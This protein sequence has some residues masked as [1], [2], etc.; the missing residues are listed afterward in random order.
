MSNEKS[1]KLAETAF[2][3]ALTELSTPEQ[4]VAALETNEKLQDGTLEQLLAAFEDAA[5]SDGDSTQFWDARDLARLLDYSDYRNFLTSVERAKQAC[6]LSGIPLED[7]FVDATEMVE[8]GSA[9]LREVETIRLS[10]YACYLIAQNADARK[11]PVA[12]AQTYFAI[13]ARRQ[14]T[15]DEAESYRP[16]PEDEKRVLLRE[17]IKEHNKNLASAAKQAG[18]V[19]PLDFAIFQ[20]AGYQ[21]LYGGLDKSGIARRKGIKAKQNILDHMGSTELAANLFRA[22]QTEE[23][24]TRDGIRGKEAANRTHHEVGAEVR[25]AIQNIGGTMPEH[26]PV[27][28]DIVKVERRLKKALT[29]KDD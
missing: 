13:Q 26:L 24:L 6:R 11:Q 29:K 25:R 1:K 9:A 18:V 23:K 15:Q 7:H 12:F 20:N 28:E 17:E 27:A 10:R 2:E 22:T 3:Q 16:L 5:R 21:G 19:K 14:E 4:R 8:V